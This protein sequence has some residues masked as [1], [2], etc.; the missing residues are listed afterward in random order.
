MR[1]LVFCLIALSACG[2]AE[3]ECDYTIYQLCVVSGDFSYE[4][5]QVS[6]GVEIAFDWLAKVTQIPNA[7]SQLESRPSTLKFLPRPREHLGG[8]TFTNEV[9]VYPTPGECLA[10]SSLV[11]EMLHW[12]VRTLNLKPVEPGRSHDYP[13]VFVN[14]IRGTGNR[15]AEWNANKEFCKAICDSPCSWY[16]IPNVS[17]WP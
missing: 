14:L 7:R 2:K 10:D 8:E 6:L 3:Q 4:P 16:G 11:H 13:I 15:T 12:G 5:S 17:E 1:K 9:R